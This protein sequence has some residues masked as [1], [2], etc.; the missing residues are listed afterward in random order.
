MAEP[1]KKKQKRKSLISEEDVAVVLRRY[2]A[3]TVVTLFQEIA[4]FPEAKIDWNA[5]VKKT[6]TGIS[7]ARECQMLWRH[8]AYRDFLLEKVEDGAEPLDDGSDL[9]SELEA[10]PSISGEA[11]IE[12]AA[13]VK[14]LLASGSSSDPSALNCATVEAPLTINIPSSQSY[15]GQLACTQGTDITIS[16]SVQ[17][18]PLSTVNSVEGL[19]GNGVAGGS[20]PARR[21]R[22][23]WT[24]EEDLQLIAAVQQH[25]ER[26]WANIVK[27]DFKGERTASQ[28]SQRWSNLRKKQKDSNTGGAGNTNNSQFS[29]ELQAA[30][31]AFHHA[32]NMPMGDGLGA[33]RSI[34]ST[35][36]RISMPS[37]STVV[38]PAPTDMSAD[39]NT[40]SEVNKK[41]AIGSGAS[42][43]L[44]QAQPASHQTDATTAIQKG[45]PSTSPTSRFASK[46]P[47]VPIMATVSSDPMIEAAAVAA[48]A[49][50][51]TPT[52][53]ASLLK[54]AQ[55][56]NAV[57]IRPGGGPLMKASVSGGTLQ[58]TPSLAGPRPNIHYIRTGGA[59]TSAPPLPS[60]SS[61][62]P[63]S[64]QPGSSHQ[65]CSIPGSSSKS[66]V[67]TAVPPL[68]APTLNS[69]EP[70]NAPVPSSP[71]PPSAS[72]EVKSTEAI[73]TKVV[74]SLP[75][76]KAKTTEE[77]KEVVNGSAN[78]LQEINRDNALHVGQMTL[79]DKSSVTPTKGAGE[80]NQI[81]A[82]D[83]TDESPSNCEKMVCSPVKDGASQ[84]P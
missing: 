43:P 27:S 3:R 35:Y 74:G 66:S 54:A 23:P 46:K 22:K 2:S 15:H 73:G 24:P 48:G 33:A 75:T 78:P 52:A 56:K 57:H 50:I 40:P 17:K 1:K 19:D 58:L 5:L 18:P 42:Q 70:Q 71:L 13:C 68:S 41:P 10:F 82:T 62:P 60:S 49:R 44:N 64:S 34:G 59:S 77:T 81:L 39:T 47:S 4:Q 31:H 80:N 67:N 36:A 63:N 16:V 25:G 11:S 51:A 20:M 30:R 79:V 38:P 53:A 26:N 55:S 65:A 21:K 72:V 76:E 14:V 12:A 45:T 32:V 7:S 37:T 29:E 61:A 28:L 84:N 9:E 69:T 8:L 6:A 83:K